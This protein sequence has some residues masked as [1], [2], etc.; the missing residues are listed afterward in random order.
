MNRRQF[1]K[2]LTLTASS[3]TI[4]GCLS[5]KPQK[6]RPNILFCI[7]DDASYPHMGAYGC[8][9]VKTPAFDRV[10]KQ[11]IL[12]TNAYTP[13]AKCAPSRSCILTGRNSW[14]LE[15]AAN[16][17]CT[18]PD[19]FKTYAEVLTENG[20][21]VGYVAKG[22]APGV[23]GEIDGKPRQLTGTPYNDKKTTPPT[24]AINSSDYAANFADFL[25]D[26]PAEQP[27]CFWYG[28]TEPHRR[29][30]YG[31]GVKKGKKSIKEISRVFSFWPDNE[32]V[33][34]DLLDYA[35]EIEYFDAHLER[36]LNLLE[37]RGELENT[38]VVVTAD[39]G[40]PFPRIKG[41][42]YELSNHLPLA[43][44]WPKGIKNPGRTVHDYI[45]FIDFAPTFLKAAGLDGEEKS[46]QPIQG[47]DLFDIF[48]SEKAGHVS[49]GRD[50]VLI[51][52][53]RHDVGRPKDQ[54]YPIR[55]IIKDGYLYIHNFEPG[56]WPAGNPETGYLNCDGS[57]TKTVCLDAR[58]NPDTIGYWTW[59]FGKRPQEELYHIAKDRECMNN[60]AEQQEYTELKTT[61]KEQLFKEL[62]EQNDPRMFGNG[63][64]FDEYLYADTKHQ[65][66][67]EKYMEGQ[68]LDAGWVNKSDFEPE[69]LDSSKPFR[70]K[71]RS[72]PERDGSI[73]R[74]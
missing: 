30:E 6:S 17:W 20:Y 54:G 40:M 45:S 38:M 41:Q 48:Q 18:F 73:R 31:S 5:Q 43:I 71:P 36:M 58:K 56:R 19:K 26:K 29:Y 3:L 27:F 33:R 59:S 21:H 50:H 23:V 9:W 34:N 39:N 51:G 46:M 47:K 35:F 22:W 74:E 2:A 68:K 69:P 25:A 64:I 61:L 16:H 28:S 65:N 57:P 44:M 14:Q 12:F 11:G 4:N 49:S 52:K 37:E 67:Y 53:E 10:A 42:E 72:R 60:L 62:E 8:D 1:L 13:N 7:A 66:F 63:Y 24:G 55:G 70:M 15:Q 32:I